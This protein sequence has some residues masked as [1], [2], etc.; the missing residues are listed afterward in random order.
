MQRE[1]ERAGERLVGRDRRA[2]VARGRDLHA[3]VAT[4]DR[5]DRAENERDGRVDAFIDVLGV[6]IIDQDGDD[7][8]EQDHEDGHEL[9]F[10]L[11]E[12]HRSFGDRRMNLAQFAARVGVF[13]T[14]ID[15]NAT[16]R[17][18]VVKGNSESEKGQGQDNRN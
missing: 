6:V 13:D 18:R 17:A 3:N 2:N 4:G 10:L 11:E 5:D 14:H 12:R 16:D 15:R 1:I 9:V 7:D 8:G